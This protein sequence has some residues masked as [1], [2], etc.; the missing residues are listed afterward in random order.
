MLLWTT[1]LEALMTLEFFYGT[2][3]AAEVAYYTYIYAKVDKK[4]YPRVTSHTRAAI[5][6]GKLVASIL[7]QLLINF[8]AMD[9][10]DLNY[11]SLATQIIATL[12]AFS[13]PKVNQSL[14]FHRKAYAT[15]VPALPQADS[16]EI[17]THEG[18]SQKSD[19]F[20][21]VSHIEPKLSPTKLLWTHFRNAYTN[22]KV[23]QWSLWYAV[24]LC[25]YLQVTAYVQLMWKDIEPSPDIAWNGAVDAVF[26]ALAAVCALVAGYIHAGRLTSQ[27]SLLLLAVLSAL[28]GGC[29]L[30]ICWTQNIYVSYSGY[31][32]F[33]ALY[34][35]IIT[36]AGAEVAR[37][38]EE[39]SFGLVFGINTMIAVIFQTIIT[40][41]IIDE[42]GLALS[43]K[44]Q[45]T[46]YAFYFIVVGIVYFIAVVIE[47][48]LRKIKKNQE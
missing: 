25:G 8:E 36:V 9:Y 12:W 13:L 27:A 4:Y 37:Y 23:V 39:D 5:F 31:I 48:F 28:E 33:G 47:Y 6:V 34:G 41:V 16:L 38:L 15:E 20:T 22:L 30:L 42:N 14:Y 24:G 21:S 46:V 45:F 17:G 19:H 7:A 10:R 26:T 32:A 29:I 18:N 44:G 3:M 11:I 40:L 1:S 43:T 35:F 2:Y